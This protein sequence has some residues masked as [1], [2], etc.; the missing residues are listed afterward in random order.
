M[1]ELPEV[2]TVRNVLGSQIKGMQIETVSVRC[3][4]VIAHPAAD[5]FCTCLIGQHI[6]YMTRRGKFLSICLKSGDRIVLHLRM[7]GGRGS[8]YCPTCQKA[9]SLR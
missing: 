7:T 4:D 9:P 2:E 6:L 8:V 1:P 3:P 5:D